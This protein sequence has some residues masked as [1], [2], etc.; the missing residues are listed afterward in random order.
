VNSYEKTIPQ[1]G[2]LRT[3]QD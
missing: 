2:F 1:I 3:C